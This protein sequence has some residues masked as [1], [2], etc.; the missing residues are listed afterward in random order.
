MRRRLVLATLTAVLLAVFLLGLPLAIAADLLLVDQSKADVQQ[1]AR[2]IALSVDRRL[3]DH[4]AVDPAALSEALGGSLRGHDLWATVQTP[5]G[6][7]RVGKDHPGAAYTGETVTS[8][9]VV[10]RA[11]VA[12]S[13]VRLDVIRAWVVIFVVSVAAVAAAVALGIVQARR[14]ARPLVQLARNAERL[15]AG[16]SRLAGIASG[17]AEVD[18]VAAELDRSARRMAATLAAERDFTSDASHQLRT[19]LTALSMR[20]EE[21]VAADTVAAAQ[22]EARIALVQVE[23]LTR[24]VQDLLARSRR[25]HHDS[26]QAL[27]LDDVVDQ[28]EQEWS[29]AFESVGRALVVEGERG[30]RVEAA[31]G[32]LAQVLSTLLDNS[33]VHGGGTVIVTTRSRGRSVVIE[34]SDEGPGVPPELGQ[35][36][37]ARSVS[38]AG[39]TGLGLALARDLATADGG[40]LELLRGEP[41]I[42][43]IFL[44]A[45]REAPAAAL[46]QLL[47]Q[48]GPEDEPS[49][50]PEPEDRGQA[51]PDEGLADVVGDHAVLAQH[52]A[53]EAQAARGD[54]Q[55]DGV[56][57]DEHRELVVHGDPLAVPEGPPPAADPG[58]DHGRADRDDGGGDRLVPQRA[59]PAA[60]HEEVVAAGVD[61]EGGGA[62]DAE[63]H[64]LAV[65][66]VDRP[67]Q[68]GAQVPQRRGHDRRA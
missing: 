29:Q 20:L 64:Q 25:A 2:T 1:R 8:S 6:N 47:G 24:V 13:D 18:Q 65:E 34:V 48:L 56:D 66:H 19:P 30:L 44:I 52:V 61:H 27:A 26:T 62:D 36:I 4:Q 45:A 23:R 12:S 49:V 15:G 59:V 46:A 42:F 21:I 58:H 7:Y 38:S 41:P 17:V 39:S 50:G 55:P 63:L 60:V 32:G 51:G 3:A 67:A 5:G 14:L 11:S 68:P 10:V 33:L 31:T 35:R 57:Q 16:E 43:G 54:Q 40:R 37:F 9:G 53:G 28:Q 22:E